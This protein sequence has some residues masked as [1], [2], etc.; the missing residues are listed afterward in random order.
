MAQIFCTHQPIISQA[1]KVSM[2]IWLGEH[3]LWKLVQLDPLGLG[4]DSP[5]SVSTSMCACIPHRQ[6]TFAHGELPLQ[7]HA[8]MNFT[9]RK[10]P[11]NHGFSLHDF[12][13]FSI[14]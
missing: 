14:F 2:I 12:A 3:Q 10:A 7:F 11:A 4:P 9:Q 13:K 5:E 8:S 6:R 1:L